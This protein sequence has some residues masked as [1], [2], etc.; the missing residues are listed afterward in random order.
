M[1]LFY[2]EKKVAL[3]AQKSLI[4]PSTKYRH[5]FAATKLCLYIGNGKAQVKVNFFDFT[6]LF[7]NNF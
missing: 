2:V 7:G 4:A 6:F 5:I 1:L 3:K